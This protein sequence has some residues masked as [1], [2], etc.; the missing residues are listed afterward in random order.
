MDQPLLSTD[1]LLALARRHGFDDV[2]VTSADVHAEA[3]ALFGAW[4]EAG[5]HADMDWMTRDPERRT[6]PHQHLPAARSVLMFAAN[7]CRDAPV[8][9]PGAGRV[10]RYAAGV[11]YHQVLDRG[12]RNVI[13][14]LHAAASGSAHRYY[15]DYGPFLERAF[16]ER[17][18]LGFVGRSANLIHP[19]FGTW[20]FLATIV[21]DAPFT[22]TPAAPGTCGQCRRCLDACPTGALVAPHE[23]DARLCI[24]YLTIENRG[25]IP[26]LLRPKIGDWLFGCDRC[27]DVCP[28]NA[29]AQAG[30]HPEIAGT[31]IAGTVLDVAEVLGLHDDDA[32]RARFS[33][34]PLRRAG[35][36][37]LLRNAAVVA[38]NLGRHDLVPALHGALH[39][40]SPL[41][42]GHAI[43]ALRRLGESVE[44]SGP[45]AGETDP[46]VR[47]EID[48]G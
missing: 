10:A 39:D 41:V 46:F 17:A 8:P 20:V 28:Y 19:R 48:A 37:G 32:F 13:G 42:R 5:R 16:A 11:D 15:V 21:T 4:L 23:V 6:D 27:Q 9:A 44:A 25:P 47:S 33:R 31:A 26:R 45:L 35:R 36:A 22:P 14:D 40:P 18:G 34:S 29:R 7:Y 38:G 12:L 1:A 2:R 43:W 30:D 3:T 24:S